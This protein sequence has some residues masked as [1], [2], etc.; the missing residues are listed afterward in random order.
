MAESL[1]YPDVEII[2]IIVIEEA[3][4]GLASPPDPG[5]LSHPT[6]HLDKEKLTCASNTIPRQPCSTNSLILVIVW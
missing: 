3:D 4:D 5:K 1:M 2:D 6:I